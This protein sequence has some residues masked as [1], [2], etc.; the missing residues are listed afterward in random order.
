MAN[1]TLLGMCAFE[2]QPTDPLTI[3]VATMYILFGAVYTLFGYRCFK[4]V[5]FLT[6]FIF[7]SVLVYLICIQE[8]VLPPYANVLIAVCAGLLFGLITMLVHYVG[9]FMTGLHTGLFLAAAGLVIA[10]LQQPVSVL[11]AVAAMLGSGLFF[12][13]INLQWQRGLTVFGTSVYGGALVAC[14]VDYLVEGFRSVKWMWRSLRDADPPCYPVV[15]LW[16][17]LLVL[18]LG[19]QCIQSPSSQPNTKYS[20]RHPVR[21]RTREQRAELRQNK[22]RYLYQVRTA[23]GDVISQNYVQ[24][25]QNKVIGPGETSTLESDA[26]HLTML[27]DGQT[28]LLKEHRSSNYYR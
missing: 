12:A 2:N 24:A 23:H 1:S 17:A 3:C 27:P 7:A 28:D 10:D 11:T 6:G 4:A 16:P 26:T 8:R 9:L 25:I 22:Y 5:M 21:A 18:G 15:G 20:G 13:I 19:I 14:S